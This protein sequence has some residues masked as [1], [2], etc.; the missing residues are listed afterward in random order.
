MHTCIFQWKRWHFAYDNNCRERLSKGQ[1]SWKDMGL[2]SEGWAGPLLDSWVKLWA[3]NALNSCCC[4]SSLFSPCTCLIIAFTEVLS[5]WHRNVKASEYDELVRTS[6]VM[7]WRCPDLVRKLNYWSP[8]SQ[9]SWK[10]WPVQKYPGHPSHLH[11]AAWSTLLYPSLA[12]RSGDLEGANPSNWKVCNAAWQDLNNTIELPA[13]IRSCVSGL[14][15]LRSEA[16]LLTRK[17]FFADCTA[18]LPAGSLIACFLSQ[19]IICARLRACVK[20]FSLTMLSPS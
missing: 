19:R 9:A 7:Y 4:S 11:P 8:W 3:I 12:A 16:K 15:L 2:A 18:F 5:A 6:A 10:L 14:K 1:T 17:I 20:S 13:A